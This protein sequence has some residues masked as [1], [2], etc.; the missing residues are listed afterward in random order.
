MFSARSH[1]S[2]A[3]VKAVPGRSESATEAQQ[4]LL[5]LILAFVLAVALAWPAHVRAQDGATVTASS[6]GT[7]TVRV[8]ET[9]WSL[10]ARYYGNG[11]KWRDLAKLNGLAEGGE[12]GIAV[13]QVLRVPGEAPPLAVARAAMAETPPQATPS[14]AVTPAAGTSAAAPAPSTPPASTPPA[15]A[16]TTP[17]V[18]S[19][20]PAPVAAPFVPAPPAAAA[21]EPRATPRIGLV[22]QPQ[23]AEA[24]G[25]DNTTIFLGPAPFNADTMQGTIELNGTESFVEPAGRRIGEFQAAPFPLGAAEW[26]GAGVV[27]GRAHATAAAKTRELQRMQQRDLVEVVLPAGADA[28][29]GTK[30]VTVTPG[31]D[32]GRGAR[33]VVPTGVLTLEEPQNGVTVARVTRLYGVIEQ[34]QMVLPFVEAPEAPVAGPVEPIETAV[35][36]ITDTPLPSLQTYLVLAPDPAIASGD[37]FELVSETAT[38]SRV[39]VVRVV[40]VSP[41]GATAIVMQQD[42]PAIRVGMQARRIGRAP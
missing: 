11:H 17:A 7:H 1:R 40:R 29:P 4:L 14:Q 25:R 3:R 33:L 18:P 23:V 34:T 38:R 32:L 22:K 13:G 16:P 9:L 31:A 24:R 19:A 15:A 6:S 2:P 28:T 42:Q 12:R 36:W 10:A 21:D 35:R 27:K 20:A 5:P 39:A 8:G 41:E 37:R 26:K 30:Y